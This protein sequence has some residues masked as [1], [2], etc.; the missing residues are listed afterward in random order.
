MQ[1][2]SG[3]DSLDP[4][5]GIITGSVAVS[6]LP[7]EVLNMDAPNAAAPD[8]ESLVKLPSLA[9]FEALLETD[10]PLRAAS[11]EMKYYVYHEYKDGVW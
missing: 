2:W 8:P 5:S 6:S 1:P 11:C 10:A 3:W 4:V 9:D 7:K